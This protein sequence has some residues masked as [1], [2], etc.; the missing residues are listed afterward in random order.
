MRPVQLRLHAFLSAY[1]RS[2]KSGALVGA[3][4]HAVFAVQAPAEYRLDDAMSDWVKGELSDSIHLLHSDTFK[5]YTLNEYLAHMQPGRS[6]PRLVCIQDM[7]K[8]LFCTAHE[9]SPEAKNAMHTLHEISELDQSTKAQVGV[10]M[11]GAAP[12]VQAFSTMR[13]AMQVAALCASVRDDN[14][15]VIFPSTEALRFKY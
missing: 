9:D 4:R 13:A 6:G 5:K 11:T 12:L 3:E 15:K 14:Q 7:T 1:W 8:L 2:L 10:V